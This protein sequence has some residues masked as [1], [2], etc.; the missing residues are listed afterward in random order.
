MK[1]SKENIPTRPVSFCLIIFLFLSFSKSC[2]GSRVSGWQVIKWEDNTNRR[3]GTES[4]GENIENGIAGI[5][6]IFTL[7]AI[8]G[9]FLSKYSAI[10]RPI[11]N[12]WRAAS[13]TRTT[14]RT[15][16]WRQRER[17]RDAIVAGHFAMSLAST[18]ALLWWAVVCH[19][20]GHGK[21]DFLLFIH[22]CLRTADG[23]ASSFGWRTHTDSVARATTSLR[24][25]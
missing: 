8:H 5:F 22:S 21:F 3:K 20:F 18:R 13:Y 6:I 4:H 2:C 17:A 12:H 23:A 7:E 1:K 9:L 10:K 16:T 11:F 14:T 25:E 19:G 15:L 24:N